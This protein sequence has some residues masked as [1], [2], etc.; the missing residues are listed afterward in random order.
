MII[1][2]IVDLQSNLAL[3]ISKHNAIA[4]YVAKIRKKE[5][6]TTNN[7]N[8]FRKSITKTHKRQD[9]QKV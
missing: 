8:I 3:H 9:G 5:Q 2:E 7:V 6:E 1:T 4:M